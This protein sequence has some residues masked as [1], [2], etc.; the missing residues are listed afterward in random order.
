MHPA[1]LGALVGFGAAAFFVLSE[2]MLLS[3]AAK[4]RAKRWGRK[5]EFDGEAKKRMRSIMMFSSCLPPALAVAFWIVLPR[6]GWA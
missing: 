5:V 3:Q 1:L 2:Y 4:E 6:M